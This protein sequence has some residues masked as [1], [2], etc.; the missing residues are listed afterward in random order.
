M[1]YADYRHC[2]ICDAK[3]FYDANL[4][5]DWEEYPETGLRNTG[6]SDGRT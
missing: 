3:T 1:A 2:D 5:Y 4:D 6:A